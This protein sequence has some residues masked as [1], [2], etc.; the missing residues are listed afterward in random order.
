MSSNY[1]EIYESQK[2]TEKEK[3]GIYLN[4]NDML[5]FE[6]LENKSKNGPTEKIPNSNNNINSIYSIL[7]KEELKNKHRNIFKDKTIQD[8]LRVYSLKKG[9]L[10]QVASEK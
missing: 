4:K 3:S 5:K 7:G 9:F 8:L 2:N 1:S 10:D 6:N